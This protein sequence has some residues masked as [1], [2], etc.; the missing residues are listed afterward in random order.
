MD[1]KQ[2]KLTRTEWDSI[3]IPVSDQEKDILKLIMEGY[4][5]PNITKNK[6]MSLFSFTK[7]EQTPENETFLYDKY[8][9]PIIQ[10]T[11]RK[12]GD[13]WLTFDSGGIGGKTGG[14]GGG[15]GGGPLKK[16]KSIDL[17]RVQNL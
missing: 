12:Y 7:I 9:A 4:E 13:G 3:E 2:T 5:N 14:G 6:T 8:F 11:I 15:G 16:M 10:R 1:L 17:V